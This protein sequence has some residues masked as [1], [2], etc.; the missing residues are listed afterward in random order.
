MLLVFQLCLQESSLHVLSHVVDEDGQ[1]VGALDARVP[2]DDLHIP[3]KHSSGLRASLA[4]VSAQLLLQ[5][6]DL[7]VLLSLGQDLARDFLQRV[8]AP[9]VG[10]I[11]V[12][13]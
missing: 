13:G 11:Q 2:E 12:R 3:I 5:L 10:D 6:E 1:Q 4:A 8:E 9:L 7:E